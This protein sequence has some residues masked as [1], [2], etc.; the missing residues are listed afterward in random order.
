MRVG[1]IGFYHESNTFIEA[2]TAFE[3]FRRNLFLEGEQISREFDRSHHEIGGFLQGLPDAGLEAVP[4][5]YTSAMP[6][7][8]SAGSSGCKVHCN[9]LLLF[10]N[11]K[12]WRDAL[13][14]VRPGCS[15]CLSK[16]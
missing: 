11:E 9:M 16:S 2:P 4:N 15:N 7:G 1:I 10:A 3:D 14:Q 12:V 6:S 8:R 13:A 5:I